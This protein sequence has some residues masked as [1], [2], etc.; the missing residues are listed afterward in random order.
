MANKFGL[1]RDIP[2]QTKREVRQRCGF[3]C[4]IC[5]VTITEYEHFFPDYKNARSHDANRIVLLCPNHHREVSKGLLPKEQVAEA[6]LNP[7]ARQVGFSTQRIESFRGIPSLK[8]GGGMLVKLTP[9]PLQVYGVNL[10]E[11]QAPE[12]GS[13]V[14]RISMN[15]ADA[16]GGEMLRVA[17]NEWIVSS[18]TWDFKL[19]GNRYIFTNSSGSPDLILRFEPPEAIVIENLRSTVNGMPIHV[20]ET[21]LSVGAMELSGNVVSNC[22]IGLSIG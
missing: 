10:I 16:V 1:N 22:G 12:E 7:K 3:G 18:E 14:T 9:I 8:F 21:S 15:L 11:F 4:A 19:V 2:E 17:S 13:E 5:G 20:T 6:S